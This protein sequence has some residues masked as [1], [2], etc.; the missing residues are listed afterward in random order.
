VGREVSLYGISSQNY[1][2][3]SQGCPIINLFPHPKKKKKKKLQKPAWYSHCPLSQ[4]FPTTFFMPLFIQILIKGKMK[5]HSW[6][7]K[8]YLDSR[9]SDEEKEN[10]RREIESVRR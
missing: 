9:V 10:W 6:K 7:R 2:N 8:M 3:E 4:R 1:H 5:F